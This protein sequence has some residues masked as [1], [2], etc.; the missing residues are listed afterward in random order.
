MKSFQ[1]FKQHGENIATGSVV[2]G[3]NVLLAYLQKKKERKLLQENP[4]ATLVPK[5]VHVGS[6]GVYVDMK[7]VYPEGHAKEQ[8]PPSKSM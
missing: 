3:L 5:Y 7:V 4:G 8:C 2:V 6:K 1:F